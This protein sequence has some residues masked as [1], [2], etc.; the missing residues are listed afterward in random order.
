M[1]RASCMLHEQDFTAQ[2]L[3]RRVIS[4]ITLGIRPCTGTKDLWAS[5]W[6]LSFKRWLVQ[7]K[8][9]QLANTVEYEYEPRAIGTVTTGTVKSLD[10]GSLQ[11]IFI[12]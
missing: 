2:S 9:W 5:A 10:I 3:P 1:D 11:T 7:S 12:V 8:R 6:A 4:T